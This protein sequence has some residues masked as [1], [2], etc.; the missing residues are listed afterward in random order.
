MLIAELVEKP[1]IGL[2]PS[3]GEFARAYADLVDISCK[4]VS[5]QFHKI[6]SLTFNSTADISVGLHKPSNHTGNL[7][8]RL[9][10]MAPGASK[11]HRGPADLT[12]LSVSAYIIFTYH[13]HQ[14]TTG[15]WAGKSDASYDKGPLYL[16]HM[17]GKKGMCWLNNFYCY[18]ADGLDVRAHRPCPRSL[19]PFSAH[20]QH[21]R[22]LRQ[23]DRA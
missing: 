20:R 14:T 12:G 17:D 7:L 6:G 21:R 16:K 5:H 11:A 2:N 1:L 23:E 22:H 8:P 10:R 18:R 13:H 19:Q 15:R 4:L 9:P 3:Q